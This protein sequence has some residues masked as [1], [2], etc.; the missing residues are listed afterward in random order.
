M[1]T[2]TNNTIKL[3][4]YDNLKKGGVWNCLLRLSTFLG[5]AHTVNK[6]PLV[7]SDGLPYLLIEDGGN[8]VKGEV[9][10]IDAKTL[11][12]IDILMNNPNWYA[13]QKQLINV[14]GAFHECWVYFLAQRKYNLL[15]NWRKMNHHSS[16]DDLSY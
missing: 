14:G 5:S 3:F 4:V 12:A 11:A 8:I 7:I 2:N 10:E 13:R 1:E 15:G 9:Y 6:H 16:F